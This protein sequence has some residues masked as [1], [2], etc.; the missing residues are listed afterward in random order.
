MLDTIGMALFI[1]QTEDRSKLQER[2]S[3]ELQERAKRTQLK[4]DTSDKLEDSSFLRGTK[5]SSRMLWVWLLM[6]AS[7]LIIMGFLMYGGALLR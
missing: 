2:L 5:T 1:R 6:F 7:I 3:A 4:T